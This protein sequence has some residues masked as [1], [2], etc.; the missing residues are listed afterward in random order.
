[1]GCGT[2]Y[3]IWVMGLDLGLGMVLGLEWGMG[4]GKRMGMREGKHQASDRAVYWT[5]NLILCNQLLPSLHCDLVSHIGGG[6]LGTEA[7]II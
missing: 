4:I 2:G 6:G 5:V 3:G 7:A 1:M